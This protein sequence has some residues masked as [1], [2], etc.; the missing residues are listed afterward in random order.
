MEQG[1]LTRLDI[2]IP[3]NAMIIAPE[4]LSCYKN[5]DSSELNAKKN[6]IFGVVYTFELFIVS[7]TVI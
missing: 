1:I 4:A 7:K 6:Q 5:I 2:G 3:Y